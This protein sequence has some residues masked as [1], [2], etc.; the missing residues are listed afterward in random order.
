MFDNIVESHHVQKIEQNNDVYCVASGVPLVTNKHAAEI[1]N[2]LIEILGRLKKFSVISL[3]D[4]RIQCRIG[5][6][7][8]EI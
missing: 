4:V 1:V 7:S 8:G 2:F 5:A 6:H 3:L